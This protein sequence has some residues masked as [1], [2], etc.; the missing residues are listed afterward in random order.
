M[1]IR[2][3]E[4]EHRALTIDGRG[5]D[6]HLG[7][8][9]AH[10]TLRH[11][12]PVC[13][14]GAV[15][16]YL[17]HRLPF[18]SNGVNL[19]SKKMKHQGQKFSRRQVVSGLSGVAAAAITAGTLP[20]VTY[21]ASKK[22]KVAIILP[23]FDQQRWK[24]ADGAYFVSRAEELGMD[25]LPIISSNN[26]P[27]LQASQVENM[28]N[29]GIDG[30]A[31]VPVDIEAA[32]AS[33][34]KCNDAGVPVVSENY[35]IPG[36]ELAGIAARDG[37]ELGR[38]LGRAVTEAAP[39]GNYVLTNGDIGT[40][41]ARLKHEGIMEIIQP[42]V[43]SGAIEIVHDQYIRG[44][45]SELARKQIE[46]ALT[47][48]DNNIAA[49]AC[50]WDGG[51]YGVIEALRAQGLAGKIFVTGEDAEPQA[52][53]LVLAKEMLVTAW[54]K[55]D[56]MGARS[57]DMLYEK[58]AGLPSSANSTFN[59]GWG[60]IP[61]D[62][63]EIVNVTIDGAGPEAISVSEFADANPWWVTREELGI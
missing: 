31:L 2:R 61:W 44:W 28:L 46:Q 5:V 20:R 58:L 11:M 21:G 29:Q 48:N 39:E 41:I 40:D 51:A 8:A 43:D 30:L 3:E 62:K 42:V 15:S 50:S 23:S 18:S 17:F 55:F 4:G 56:S 22:F 63:I 36:V 10:Q 57:A 52:L 27:I 35:I 19:M 7:R 53:K 24:A 13:W 14:N 16:D 34:R 54:T 49:V 38:K 37:V 60:D 47:A 1:R 9:D 33:V 6:R 26:D 59:N 12:A 25:P 32:V 45:S